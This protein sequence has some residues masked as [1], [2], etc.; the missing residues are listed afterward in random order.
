MIV[1]GTSLKNIQRA[2]HLRDDNKLC[3]CRY[4]IDIL[5]RNS[6]K[7]SIKFIIYLVNFD[8]YF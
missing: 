2:V 3:D 6:I 5:R 1:R 8:D 4:E 7:L